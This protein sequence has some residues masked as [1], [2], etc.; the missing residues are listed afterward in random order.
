MDIL[1]I[2]GTGNLSGALAEHLRDTG[3]AVT[4]LTTGR[5]PVPPG[6]AV[7]HADRNAPA[8]FAAAVDGR[9]FDAVVNFLGFQPPQIRADHRLFRGRLGQYVFISSA[10][11]YRKPHRRLPLTED[12]PLGNRFSEYARGKIA[13]ERLLQRLHAPDFPVTIVR[14]SHTF[15]PSWIPSP[16]SGSDF[17]VAARI[18]AG[19]PVL[20]H[21]Q[22]QSLWT[23]TAASDFAAGLAGLLGHAQA[24]GEAFHITHDQ[25]LTWN[26]I[27]Y[28][29]GL[30]LGRQPDLVPIPSDFLARVCPG[31]EG[32]LQGDKAEHAVF[33][34]TKIKRFL[35]DFE[36]R[37]S[38]RTALRE[39]VAWFLADPARQQVSAEQD[40][41]QDDLIRQWADARA[42]GEA[43]A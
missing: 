39:S 36:C 17:T 41:L 19:R 18:L 33:D 35:P 7:L 22:G 37:K 29:I 14:P 32:R 23:L 9:R 42:R 1:L 3:H 2:G 26:A 25:V 20:V 38:V 30:A 11:V 10:T 43:G 5:R 31:A 40:R 27:Y 16:L 24:A 13:C 28:E 21:D 34:N 6:M 4:L 12:S 8:A 15:G